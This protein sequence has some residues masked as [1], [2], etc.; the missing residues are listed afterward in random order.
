MHGWPMRVSGR[1]SGPQGMIGTMCDQD[2]E[3][4]PMG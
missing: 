3:R 2:E 1:G 4:N